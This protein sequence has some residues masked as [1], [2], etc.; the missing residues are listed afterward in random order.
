MKLLTGLLILFYM[1]DFAN[2]SLG[3]SCRHIVRPPPHVDCNDF[4]RL[5]VG[6]ASNRAM[7]PD[8]QP[9]ISTVLPEHFLIPGF[10][11]LLGKGAP[12]L[13]RLLL[14]VPLQPVLAMETHNEALHNHVVLSRSLGY[15]SKALQ[16]LRR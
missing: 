9:Q 5:D 2:L 8:P 13:A 4:R 3:C 14:I 11:L 12:S 6:A 1:K 10:L 16:F 7:S 15:Q